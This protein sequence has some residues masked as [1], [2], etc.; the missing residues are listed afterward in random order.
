VEIEPLATARLV[1][2]PFAEGDRAGL[3]EQW[4]DPGVYRYLFDGEAPP[5]DVV[6]AQIASSRESF[7]RRGYGLFTVALAVE[8]LK[9]IGFCGLRPFGEE[10]RI[11]IL[12]A[13]RPAY[14][15]QGLAT[16]AGRAVL[17]FAFH[18]ARLPEVW[19]GADLANEASFAVMRRLGMSPLQSAEAG[20]HNRHRITRADFAAHGRRRRSREG[21]ATLAEALLAVDEVATSAARTA[22]AWPVAHALNHCAQSIEYSIA[23]FPALKPAWVRATVGRLV[24]RRFLA[25]GYMGHDTEAPIAGAPP[26][27][28]PSDVASATERLREAVQAFE[29]FEGSPAVHFVYG[30]VTKDEY[31][32]LHLMH[33]SDHLRG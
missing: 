33:L 1:L 15:G 24:L 27:D 3:L 28:S 32:R 2:R 5:L 13:L 12:Y 25:R 30:P 31:R 21:F 7:A 8:P 23:G 17:A 4:G 10:G 18:D 6:D 22:G 19:A 16:E 14:W 26:L 20:E 29:R 9:L 11:E